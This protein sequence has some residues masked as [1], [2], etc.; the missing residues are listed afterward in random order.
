M[1][2]KQSARLRGRSYTEGQANYRTSIEHRGKGWIAV[3]N[4]DC[5]QMI[6]GLPLELEELDVFIA[7]LQKLRAKLAEDVQFHREAR[8]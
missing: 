6:L 1:I 8:S 2:V 4:V 7:D 3:V 5:D